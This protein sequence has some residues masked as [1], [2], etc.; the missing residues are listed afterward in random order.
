MPYTDIEKRREANRK[1]KRENPETVKAQKAR[2]R[3]RRPEVA[4]AYRQNNKESLKAIGDAWRSANP[5]KVKGYRRRSNIKK[6]YGITLEQRNAMLALQGDCCAMCK[7]SDPGSIQG[8]CIDHSHDTGDIRGILCAKCN[9]SL[10]QA[11]DAL[12][13]VVAWAAMAISYLKN[14]TPVHGAT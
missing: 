5:E 9:T 4:R 13:R 1:W 8:W 12:E 10:G 11:G 7:C 6:R 3:A 2:Y 14:P